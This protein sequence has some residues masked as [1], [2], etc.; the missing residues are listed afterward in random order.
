[1]AVMA[2]AAT[3]R[4]RVVAGAP[5]LPAESSPFEPAWSVPASAAFGPGDPAA[6]GWMPST[7]A[8]GSAVGST[9][10]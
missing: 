8:V 10:M 4:L 7:T 6:S 1:M 3:L 5:E 9:G 2:P